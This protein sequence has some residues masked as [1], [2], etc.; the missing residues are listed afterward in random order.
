M[1]PPNGQ[2]GSG[3]AATIQEPVASDGVIGMPA[4]GDALGQGPELATRAKQRTKQQI[5]QNRFVIIGAGAIVV[6]LLIFVATSMPSKHPAPKSKN[7]A[8]RH[9]AG[10]CVR[11]RRYAW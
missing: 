3:R 9:H 2:N 1:I 7:G 5:Q 11:K 10:R 8:G 6:A 4:A